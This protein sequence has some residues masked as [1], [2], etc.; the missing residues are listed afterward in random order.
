MSME[1]LSAEAASARKAGE[2]ARKYAACAV[3]TVRTQGVWHTLADL[4]A[5]LMF[6]WRHGIRAWLPVETAG[7]GDGLATSW[8]R[9]AVQYQGA[10]P[11]AARDLFRR[12]PA[13]FEGA[14]FIDYGCGKGRGLLLG[15][16]A[17]FRRLIGVEAD[18][19]LVSACT[20]NLDRARG[21]HSL[22]PFEFQVVWMDAA[23]FTPPPGAAVCFLYNPFAGATLKSVA[24]V[25]RQHADSFPV[26]ILYLNPEGLS[27]FTNL[28]F[29]VREEILRK[30]K[31]IGALL[32]GTAV[33]APESG[34]P[35][36]C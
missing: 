26:A 12:L 18:Q 35:E 24:R 23:G 2:W 3:R 25:L 17:G 33:P 28:G 15:A 20:R 8:R 34:L 1:G 11:R 10:S 29:V 36:G 5:E 30:G 31:R 13:V 16:E 14:Q 6:D 9:D 7:T 21:I 19:E 27:V 32:I 22:P 4:L